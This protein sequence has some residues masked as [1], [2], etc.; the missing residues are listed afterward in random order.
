MNLDSLIDKWPS[1]FVARDQRILD[2]FSG[3]LLNA[4]TLANA[5]SRGLG[6]E[7]KIRIGRRVAYPVESLVAWLKDRLEKG[8]Q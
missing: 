3:G 8:G 4:K 7:G 2:R 1:P 6:P 5:D